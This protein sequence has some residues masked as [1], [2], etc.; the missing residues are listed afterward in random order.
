MLLYRFAQAAKQQKNVFG[1]WLMK[2]G[3]SPVEVIPK[4]SS[5]GASVA[6]P[7]S[8][9]ASSSDRSSLPPA[10]MNTDKFNKSSTKDYFSTFKP[11]FVRAGVEVAPINRFSASS[12]KVKLESDDME[13][14]MAAEISKEG[15]FERL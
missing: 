8:S 3:T 5:A 7:P 10:S 1:A 11:F 4:P 2:A 9:R 6:Q 12:S 13:V 15:S 14:D